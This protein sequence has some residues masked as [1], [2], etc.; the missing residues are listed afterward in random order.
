MQTLETMAI[1]ARAGSREPG[2]VSLL[3]SIVRNPSNPADI[4]SVID[5][6]LRNTFVYRGERDEVLRTVPY[7]LHDLATLRRMEGD[8]DD[9]AIM[10][11]AMLM[12]AGISCRMTA[13]KAENPDEFD[14]VFSEAR[15]GQNWI[16]VDPTVPLGTQ[17][18]TFG[19]MSEVVC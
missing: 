2:T 18:R 19:F 13:I 1:L 9:M 17:Y 12:G 4:V 15:V 7:M 16:P 3:S 8:C 6:F 10:G 11:C 14:H 5:N